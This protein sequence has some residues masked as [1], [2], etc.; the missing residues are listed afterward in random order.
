MSDLQDLIHKTS[1]DCIEQ[2][3]AIE[4]K[5]VIDLLI[6]LNAIRRDALG[7]L[8]AFNTDG[9]KVIYLTGLEREN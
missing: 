3:K 4:R 9:T 7:S 6:H 8:V 5:R 2:G 1:M